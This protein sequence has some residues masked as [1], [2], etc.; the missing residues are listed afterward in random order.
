M[1]DKSK[2]RKKRRIVAAVIAAAAAAALIV[3]VI[4]PLIAINNAV[5]NAPQP[6]N[7]QTVEKGSI[8]KTVVGSGT[9]SPVI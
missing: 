4:M 6:Y 8:E 9:L 7:I 2:K 5:K 3:F 1:A